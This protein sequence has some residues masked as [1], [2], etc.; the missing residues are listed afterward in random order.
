MG[1]HILYKPIGKT[2]LEMLDSVKRDK[3]SYA[4][5]LDPMAHGL[6]L[7]LSNEHCLLQNSF[8]NFDKTYV[9]ET[10]IGLTTDTGDILGVLKSDNKTREVTRQQL[11]LEK[12]IGTMF[13]KYPPFSSVRVNGKPLWYWTKQNK[14]ED[15]EIPGKNVYIYD[16][17]LLSLDKIDN[18]KEVIMSRLDMLGDRDNKFRESDIRYQWNNYNFRDNY[19]K[20]KIRADVSCGTYIRELSSLICNNLKVDG[21][22]LDIYRERVGEYRL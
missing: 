17:Q 6:L 11:N 21:V 3:K 8:H 4:G 15:I 12:F 19:I 14:L 22:C 16:L 7:V 1:I 10:I 2:P 13:Q 20:L 5:R 9:F 18:L